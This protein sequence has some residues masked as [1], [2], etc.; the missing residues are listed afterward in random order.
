M[1]CV[2]KNTIQKYATITNNDN[3]QSCETPKNKLTYQP[4]QEI[5]IIHNLFLPHP[6]VY[7]LLTHLWYYLR[8]VNN[9]C[10][11]LKEGKSD[12]D[13]WSIK[14]RIMTKVIS[15]VLSIDQFEQQF[16]VV[17][18]MMQLPRLKYHVQTIGIHPSL[19]NNALY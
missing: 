3:I 6:Q 10:V 8:L 12:Q 19:S 2:P 14:S 5:I 13:S 7:W 4:F 17:K 1:F 15:Y 16:V 11:F 18:G 9:I